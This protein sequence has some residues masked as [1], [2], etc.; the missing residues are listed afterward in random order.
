MKRNK[1]LLLCEAPNHYN[2]IQ[3]SSLFNFKFCVDERKIRRQVT[4]IRKDN[5]PSYQLVIDS[6]SLIVVL[7]RARERFSKIL[8]ELTLGLSVLK[9]SKE[10]RH[11]LDSISN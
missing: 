7:R 6:F 2:V 4:K 11:G 3:S 10:N 9:T 5:I 1:Q 8:I